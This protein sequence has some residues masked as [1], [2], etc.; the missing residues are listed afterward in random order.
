M[1]K[2]FFRRLTKRFFIVVNIIAAILFLLGSYGY[3][4]SPE[5][6][7]PL[8]LLTLTAFYF[9]LILI[10]FIFFWLFI[11]PG[12]ALISVV[13]ILLAFKPITN[14]LPLRLSHTFTKT[15]QENSLRVM[16]WNVAQFN[17]MG[18]EKHPR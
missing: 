8:G 14:I 16:T 15:K 18:D 11:K 9:L 12:R 3:L 13:A 10:A 1:S 17:V 4:F 6:F 5:Y 2:S 7:W